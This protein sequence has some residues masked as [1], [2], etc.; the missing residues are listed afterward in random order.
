VDFI[1]LFL[2]EDKTKKKTLSATA[3]SLPHNMLQ[4]QQR[5]DYDEFGRHSR[6]HEV[7]PDFCGNSEEYKTH[8][9]S[10]HSMLLLNW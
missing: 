1:R 10:H 4:K 8:H 7:D 5:V 2:P 6:E 9:S 3:N